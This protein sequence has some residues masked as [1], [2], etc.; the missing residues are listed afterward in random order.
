[1]LA[2]VSI[3]LGALLLFCFMGTN[4]LQGMVWQGDSNSTAKRFA[5]SKLENRAIDQLR[6]RRSTRDAL[7]SLLRNDLP[8]ALG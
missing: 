6:P 2:T 3:W 7:P 5:N 4:K 8:F 1:M